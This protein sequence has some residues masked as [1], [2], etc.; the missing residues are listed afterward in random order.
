MQ[1]SLQDEIDAEFGAEGPTGAT[2]PNSGPGLIRTALRT[3]SD[4]FMPPVCIACRTPLAD[5]DS[6]CPECWRGIDFIRAPLCDRLGL[7]LPFDTGGTMIS[8]AAVADPPA[9]DRARAV[10]R[11]DA[12]LRRLVHDLKFHDRHD[13]LTL[14]ARMMTHAGADLLRDADTVVPV[15]LNRWRL[16]SRRFNQAALLAAAVGKLSG[17]PYRPMALARTRH[18]P[19]Q[20]DLTREQRRANVAGAFAVPPRHRREVEGRAIVLVDDVITTGATAEACARALKRAGARRV[21]ALALGL[22]S[23][24]ARVTT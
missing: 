16:L 17:V 23:D 20:V 22:V 7:P 4:V 3:L 14:L 13:T 5:H 21:D 6:L 8:A 19:Q 1:T 24:R 10:G 9:Y 18:T 12:T 15:P 11:F 2:R